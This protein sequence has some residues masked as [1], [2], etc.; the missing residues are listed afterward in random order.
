MSTKAIGNRKLIH[1]HLILR[2]TR[3]VTLHKTDKNDPT[4]ILP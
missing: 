2:Y 1:S 3:I 4:E